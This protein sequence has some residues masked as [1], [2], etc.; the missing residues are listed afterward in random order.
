VRRDQLGLLLG[1]L[2]YASWGLLSPV[3]GELLHQ[4]G[5]RPLE[6]NAVRFT[7]ATVPLL[8]LLGPA[9][10][11]EGLRLL[12]RPGILLANV[13]ANASLTLFLYA[14]VRV[15]PTHATLAFYTAPLF[16]AA[17]AVPLLRERV[18]WAFLPAAAGLL[19]GG[20]LA[21][22]GLA[23]PQGVDALGITLAVLSAVVWA[24]ASVALRKATPGVPLK[25]LIGASFV[26]GTLWYV[27][28]ALAFEGVPD[29]AG[30]TA[31]AWSWMALYVAIPTVASFA[32]FTASLQ[33]APAGAV[34]LLVGAELAFT[35]LFA[36]LLFG[37]RFAPIQLAGLAIV[38]ASV[39]AYLWAAERARSASPSL[40]NGEAGMESR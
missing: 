34:N 27:P 36:A 39:T 28:L 8:L 16:T 32:L 6:L 22:Y 18:G 1:F 15:E 38:L 25:P 14:L 40:I 17:L 26:A 30:K 13:L 23:S 9:A 4:H 35:A 24:L 12:G 33:R 5:F 3:G 20:Y 7:L 11:R 37:A 29:L 2:A 31:E 21:L 10:S 19:I